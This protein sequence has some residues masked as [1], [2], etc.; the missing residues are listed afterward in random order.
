ME[1][2]NAP[3]FNPRSAVLLLFFFF[4]MRNQIDL[5]RLARVIGSGIDSA[6]WESCSK[7]QLL[8][9]CVYYVSVSVLELIYSSGGTPWNHEIL[10]LP[11][12][13]AVVSLAFVFLFLLLFCL[14]HDH[15][16]KYFRISVFC[17]AN[18]YKHFKVSDHGKK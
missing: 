14:D 16:L 10:A 17:R 2:K 8:F 9:T 18:F 5:Y 1:V 7:Q 15:E 4:F 11:N 13:H 12:E 3:C 6:H